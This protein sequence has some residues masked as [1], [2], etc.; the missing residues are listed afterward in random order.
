MACYF[1][2]IHANDL[3]YC[4]DDG[5]ECPDRQAI[6]RCVTDLLTGRL[7]TL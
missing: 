2:D 5:E 1:F 6:E 3:S 7:V 4:D